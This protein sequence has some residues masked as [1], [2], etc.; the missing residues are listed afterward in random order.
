MKNSLQTKDFLLKKVYAIKV[1]LLLVVLSLLTRLGAA[2][3]N[4]YLLYGNTRG[5]VGLYFQNMTGNRANFVDTNLSLGYDSPKDAL[6]FN[7]GGAAWLATRMFEA[8]RGDFNSTKEYFVITELYG[9]FNPNEKFRAQVGRFR[10]DV[11]WIKYYNQGIYTSVAANSNIVTQ[12]MWVH[13]NAYVD[14]H[15]MQQFRN[16]F[17]SIGVFYADVALNLP[18]SPLVVTPYIYLAPYRF[19]S[20][21]IK[22][23]IEKPAVAES[24]LYVKIHLLSYIGKNQVI[25]S[26]RTDG[27]G[28][29][30]WIES[31]VKWFGVRFGGG[32][33]NVSKSGVSGIDAYRHND[34]FERREGLFY[35]DSVTLYGVL[36]YTFQNHIAVQ[37]ALRNTRI[38]QKHVFNWEANARFEVVEDVTVGGGFVGM[39]N[40]A[41]VMLD[42]NIFAGDGRNYLLGRAFVQFNF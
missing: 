22:V 38:G 27:D 7:F 36:E 23:D 15:R 35:P 12:F 37:S 42:D 9:Q 18:E 11:E 1:G 32:T 31:G 26:T 4:D 6:G 2:D 24:I 3:V 28:Y 19:S 10:A 13:S 14:K 30:V 5:H 8:N 39:L 40:T 21:G 20:F 33:I 16:P 34:L 41:N 17:H 29:M 25:E